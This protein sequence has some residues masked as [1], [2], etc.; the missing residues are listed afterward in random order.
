M[1]W[2]E[3]PGKRPSLSRCCIRG[4]L[5]KSSCDCVPFLWS[6]ISKFVRKIGVRFDFQHRGISFQNDEVMPY[7]DRDLDHGRAW[8]QFYP[9]H[10]ARIAVVGARLRLFPRPDNS[11]QRRTVWLT[12]QSGTNQSPHPNSLLT[13]N[14]TGKFADLGLSKHF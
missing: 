6:P 3:R 9:I 7:A 12:M 5:Y 10:Q 2:L 4:P 14:L 1:W 8:A 11:A 13:G